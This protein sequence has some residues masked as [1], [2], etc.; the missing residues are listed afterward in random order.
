MKIFLCASKRNYAHVERIKKELELLGHD[1]TPPNGYDE[2]EKEEEMSRLSEVEYKHWKAGMLRTDKEIISKNDAIL[3]LNFDKGEE[4]NYIGGS[5]FLE[6]YRAFDMGKK[7][8]L[9]NEI[10]QNMLEDEIYGMD[11]VVILGDLGKI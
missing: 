2:P 7:I 4:K 9:Y 6:V 8:Y 3:V 10:P 5:T 11:P 1:T